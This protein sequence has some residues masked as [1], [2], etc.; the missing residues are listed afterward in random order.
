[1]DDRM[2]AS[3]ALERALEAGDLF[4]AREALGNP[5]DWPN[6]LDPYLGFTVLTRALSCA[7]LGTIRE[8][9]AAG[10]N[11]NLH[12]IDDGFPALIDVIHHRREDVPA[13]RWKDRHDVLVALIAAGADVHARGLNGWTALHVACVHDDGDAVALL[14]DAG[15]DPFARTNIDDF[16]R[17]IDIA[18]H[19]LGAA[20]LVLKAWLAGQ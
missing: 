1:M 7:P 8:L 12:L 19:H 5:S 10:A 16:E 14:L 20:N 3:V 13:R 15:A 18:E 4:A 9:L 2:R 11:P 6:A 17:P